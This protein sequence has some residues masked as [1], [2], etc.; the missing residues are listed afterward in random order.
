MEATQ[1]KSASIYTPLHRGRKEI[2]LLEIVS[3]EPEIAF[4]THVVSLLDDPIFTALSYVWGYP[5][6][7]VDV[8]VD[9]AKTPVTE[10]LTNAV[11]D[12][13]ALWAQQHPKRI[14]ESMRL[15]ADAICIN[16]QDVVEKGFQVPLMREI[17]SGAEQVL[18]W[19]GKADEVTKSAFDALQ[20][21]QHGISA[22]GNNDL[23]DL[24][25]MESHRDLC[26]GYETDPRGP[27]LGIIDLMHRPYWSRV[28]IT[29]PRGVPGA[30]S[31]VHERPEYSGLR[32][33]Q[34][35][36]GMARIR[37]SQPTISADLR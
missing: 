11:K 24:G 12:I 22:L 7:W 31:S 28:W 10:N 25:W 18:S 3:V 2:R 6:T 37:H 8:I 27:W 15:W 35:D 32:M 33:S 9:G 20:R 29:I 13:Y 21:I 23:T 4:K 14:L 1:A 16:Q 36:S 19:L 17:Y 34:V 26:N 5:P 30:V